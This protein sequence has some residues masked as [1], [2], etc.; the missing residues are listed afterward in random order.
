[1]PPTCTSP[2]QD[3][4]KFRY[5]GNREYIAALGDSRTQTLQRYQANERALLRKG[6]WEPFQAVIQEYINLGHVQPVPQPSLTTA[7]ESYYLPMHGVVKS[8]S[9]STKF[10]VMFDASAKTSSAL[11]LNDTL[12]VGP[13]LHPNLDEILLRFRTYRVALTG[14]ISKMFREVQL[15]EQ[16]RHLHRFLWRAQPSDEICDYQMNRVT[17]GVASSPHLAV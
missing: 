11:S 13:T 3:A 14:D 10:R 12:L 7:K 15:A 5:Q 1:M 2:S 9:T 6:T 8:S 4:T 17:F 16:D